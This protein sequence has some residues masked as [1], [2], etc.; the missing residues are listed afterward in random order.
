MA[1]HTVASLTLVALL[2]LSVPAAASG[3]RNMP[4]QLKAF[5]NIV[6]H[7][8]SNGY[9]HASGKLRLNNTSGHRMSLACTVTVTWARK[10]GTLAKRSDHINADVGADSVRK[11]HFH[12]R[13]HDKE[14]LFLNIPRNGAPHCR[15][16]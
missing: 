7:S 14:G 5:V 11:F 15:E 12:V 6:G 10:N 8:Y 13:F 3:Q 16:A 1:R 9:H 4:P 2:A